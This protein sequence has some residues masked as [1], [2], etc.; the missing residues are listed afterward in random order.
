M[1]ELLE[2]V[3]GLTTGILISGMLVGATIL[4]TCAV[5][6]GGCWYL[7]KRRASGRLPKD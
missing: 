6:G 7:W 3:I 5:A 4:G 1:R 2:I